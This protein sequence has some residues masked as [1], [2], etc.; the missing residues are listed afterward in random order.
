[1][2]QKQGDHFAYCW[3]S[4]GPICICGPSAAPTLHHKENCQYIV[5]LTIG[6]EPPLICNC[7][8]APTGVTRWVG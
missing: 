2:P 5:S 1:M 3:A 7:K 4:P 6:E 8:A